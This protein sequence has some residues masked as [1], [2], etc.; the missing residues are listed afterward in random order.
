[1]QRSLVAPDDVWAV[2]VSDYPDDRAEAQRV[3]LRRA[4]GGHEPRLLA[5]TRLLGDTAS[6]SAA[7]QFAEM[8]AAAEADPEARG[9]TALVTSLD[10]EGVVACALVRLP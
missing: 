10:R 9:R 8:L 6:A 5:I 4:F 1:L 3:G 2:A 7:F